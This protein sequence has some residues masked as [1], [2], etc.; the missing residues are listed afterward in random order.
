MRVPL[1]WLREYV[2][3]D[4]APEELAA[5]LTMAGLSVEAIEDLAAPLRGI[6]VGKVLRLGRHPGAERL[7]V[8]ETDWGEGPRTLVTA[9]TNL[10]EGDLVPVA[11]VGVTLPGG[12]AIEAAVF[13]GVVSE[14]MLCSAAELGLE[15][16][17][18]GILVFEGDWTPGTPAAEALGMAELVLEIELTP[19]RADCLGLVGVARETA[20]V[21][22]GRL[23]LPPVEPRA[24]G[25][26]VESLAGVEVLAPDLCPRYCGKVAIDVRV[27]P[28]PGWMQQRLRAAGVR[29]INNIVDVTNYVM[30]EMNQP[31]HAFDLDRLSG[32]RLIIRTAR[33]GERLRTLDGTE[34]ELPGGALVIADPAGAVAVAGVM[35]GAE[36]EVTGATTRVFLEGACFAP[37]GIRRTARALAMRTEASLRFERGV[38]AASTKA[39]LDRAARLLEEIG[40]GR[41]ARGT[42]DAAARSFEP[43]TI[44]FSPA[45]LNGLLG[46]SLTPEEIGGYLNRLG[47]ETAAATGGMTA[48]VPTYRQDVEGVADLAEEV[49]RLHGYDRIPYAYPPSVQVGQRTPAQAFGFRVRRLLRGLGQTEVMTYSFCAAGAEARLRPSA[50]SGAGD[51]LRILA[52][53]SEDWAVMRTT[54][55]GGILDAL[56][57]NTRKGREDAAI[58]EMA[59][60]YL[61]T[62]GEELPREPLHLAG[63][64]MGGTPPRSWLEKP[65]PYDFYDLKGLLEDLLAGLG[66]EAVFAPAEHA[67]FHPGRCASLAAAGGEPFGIMGEAHPKI[68]AAYGLRGRI[69]LYELDLHALHRAAI[70]ELQAKPL[71]RYPAIQRDLAVVIPADYALPD[72]ERALLGLGGDLLTGVELFD[73]YVGAQVGEGRKS[74]AFSLT[75]R[76]EDRTLTDTE[77]NLAMTRIVDGLKERCGAVLR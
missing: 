6:V 4:L 49:A 37:A 64:L 65:R 50:E 69:Q 27:A 5:R 77:V 9:A 24:E 52:P 41:V 14:G 1:S 32:R 44:G 73:V 10:R 3:F 58:F 40:A 62:P 15:K 45:R 51:P 26:D 53:L 28:S 47:F 74:M 11:P 68:A 25:P 61:P 16:Q 13:A 17:S 54:L 48:V 75:F 33:P 30:L 71:P 35:G 20:A 21:A 46:T 7:F 34:R 57:V 39:A 31:L 67:A 2:E 18:D 36:S 42:I 22:G 60:V 66:V 38:D 70:N 12:M 63:G 23:R 55:L 8:A 56:A 76:A 19:N 72:L 59:R 43:R 29:P